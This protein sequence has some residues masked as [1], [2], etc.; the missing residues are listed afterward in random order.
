MIKRNI[1]SILIGLAAFLLG[2]ESEIHVSR[3][4][5][6]EYLLENMAVMEALRY[7]CNLGRRGN[8]FFMGEKRF[9]SG[10]ASWFIRQ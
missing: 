2:L 10:A 9:R 7:R 8:L 5:L 3:D 6:R 4:P 1:E